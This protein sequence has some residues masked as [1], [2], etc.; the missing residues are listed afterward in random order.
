MKKNTL[1]LAMVGL[2]TCLLA[3]LAWGQDFQKDYNLPQG[4]II[5]ISN[6]SG[7]IQVKGYNGPTLSISG[8]RE[9]RDKN[10]VEIDDQSTAGQVSLKVQYP[11]EGGSYDASVRFIVQV[12]LGTRYVYKSLSTA[13]GDVSVEN[14][15]GEINVKSASGDITISQVEGA[16]NVSAAS[17][18]I[19]VLGAS[20]VVSANTASG[21]VD[22]E[23]VR[24]ADEGE[25]KFSS[26]S[27][28]VTVKVPGQINAQVDMSTASGS[29]KTDFPLNIEDREGH[30]QKAAGTLGSGALKVKLSSASGDVRLVNK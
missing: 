14:V 9:G 19:K 27:G 5:S 10:V 25:F 11:Q 21:D 2:L 17:G 28:D 30:G 26:A 16:V 20:G 7:E 6:V 4:G 3:T 29:V 1:R 8:I 15:A 23:L 24:V 22:V 12:P 18:D 13:S